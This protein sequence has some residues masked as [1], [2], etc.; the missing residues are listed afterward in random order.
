MRRIV[1]I[2]AL[3]LS[4]VGYSETTVIDGDTWNY[5]VVNNEVVLE[6]PD[7]HD[8]T[9][10][11]PLPV[12]NK[13]GDIK[14][15]DHINGLPVT[16]IGPAAFCGV[17]GVIEIPATVTNV[18]STAILGKF[19][20]K[21]LLGS[22]LNCNVHVGYLFTPPEA[23]LFFKG[24]KPAFNGYNILYYRYIQGGNTQIH[25]I[26]MCYKY[27][28]RYWDDDFLVDRT[29]YVTTGSDW[30]VSSSSKLYGGEIKYGAAPVAI[31]YD[32][33]TR[34]LT[35][36]CDAPGAYIFY[37]K[38]GASLEDD[39]VFY[40]SPLTINKVTTIKAYAV[41]P[42]YPY[43]IE[44][45]FECVP[46]VILGSV[47][48][49]IT[50]PDQFPSFY[51]KFGSDIYDALEQKTGKVS[52]D[53]TELTVL[54]DFIAGTDPTDINDVLK[55]TIVMKDGLPV[56]GHSPTLSPEEEAKR[57]YTVY[58]KRKLQDA[59]WYEVFSVA[60]YHFFKVS[61]RLK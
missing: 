13:T 58:G 52:Y 46:E 34:R 42:G 30:E 14:V 61:V 8:Y 25:E 3:L 4:V 18:S 2:L 6:H 55:A 37:N 38:S 17:T 41:V 56:I 47:V 33:L 27:G 21:Q 23:T 26:R 22:D 7:V 39:K 16:V 54:D 45:E 29:V 32:G 11:R 5:I 57:V 1:V 53:G 12:V 24:N 31:N 44:S 28:E 50:W 36:S 48:V 15:P 59:K 60:D 40:S 9:K 49:P 10:G 19:L 51:T 20:Q 43:T 35:L